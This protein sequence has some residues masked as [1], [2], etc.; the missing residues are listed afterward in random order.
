MALIPILRF[1]ALKLIRVNLYLNLMV[2]PRHRRIDGFPFRDIHILIPRHIIIPANRINGIFRPANF[3]H[4]EHPT[5]H[6]GV[7]WITKQHRLV[8]LHD[9]LGAGGFESRKRTACLDDYFGMLIDIRLT[10][11]KHISDVVFPGD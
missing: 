10:K 7:H 9:H 8:H 5:L 2:F 11:L 1:W 4:P 6:S 3:E